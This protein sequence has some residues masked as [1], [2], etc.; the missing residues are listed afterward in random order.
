METVTLVRVLGTEEDARLKTMWAWKPLPRWRWR[1]PRC[2]RPA[3]RGPHRC[4]MLTSGPKLNSA[5]P[6][7][8]LSQSSFLPLTPDH[9]RGG[10]IC[11]LSSTASSSAR[12]WQPCETA[13]SPP[14]V[15]GMGSCRDARTT[16]AP[17]PF[18]TALRHMN[19]IQV[20]SYAVAHLPDI[21]PKANLYGTKG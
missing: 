17:A 18:V 8:M 10:Y 21:G 15:K 9:R 3:H 12:P 14:C 6:V 7:V 19:S 13:S 2:P 1:T 16:K 11:C 4:S 5:T 20:E